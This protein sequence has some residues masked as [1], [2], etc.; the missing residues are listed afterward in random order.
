MPT[1]LT[2]P[3]AL[4]Q[5]QRQHLQTQTFQ[6]LPLQLL[7]QGPAL[8]L[9][10]ILQQLRVQA[11]HLLHQQEK[12]KLRRKA[13]LQKRQMQQ[14]Q[15]IPQM[16]QQLALS[17]QHPLPSQKQ[18]QQ[19]KV[20]VL[21]Q[22]QKSHWILL[23][24]MPPRVPYYPHLGKQKA[25]LPAVTQLIRQHLRLAAAAATQQLMMSAHLWRQRLKPAAATQQQ[26]MSAHLWR[27]RLKP[28][29]ATQQQMT[30]AHLWR[31]RLKP[32]AATQQQMMSAHLW[33]Q[34]QKP[35]TAIRQQRRP[36]PAHQQ[37]RNSLKSSNQMM[38]RCHLRAVRQQQEQAATLCQSFQSSQL[39][40]RQQ[41]HYRSNVRLHMLSNDIKER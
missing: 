4:T 28:A 21:H 5:H 30:S 6:R 41:R 27:Q 32:A 24:S 7:Q 2:L 31:Q 10:L 37:Q 9:H 12:L 20:P 14:M 1:Q 18:Q 25:A 26:M 23:H 15:Q 39:P 13:P 36:A 35:A 40:K 11:R 19:Q 8:N 3:L 34:R 22:M 29:A 38:Q 16:Q 17:L 33:R